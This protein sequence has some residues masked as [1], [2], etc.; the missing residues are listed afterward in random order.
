[1]HEHLEL[2]FPP[3][4]VPSLKDIS[5]ILK[6]EFKLRFRKLDGAVARYNDPLYDEKR[7]IVS[8]VLAQLVIDNALVI[9]IDESHIRSDLKKGFAW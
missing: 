2:T 6:E 4:Q 1:M 7:G 8:R 5:S 3:S 9:S